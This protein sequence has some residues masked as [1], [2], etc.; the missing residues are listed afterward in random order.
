MLYWA[1]IGD[2][3]AITLGWD[4]GRIHSVIVE[5]VSAVRNISRDPESGEMNGQ[6]D[7]VLPFELHSGQRP[8]IITLEEL[9]EFTGNFH[10]GQYPVCDRGQ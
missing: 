7:I 5:F 2:T 8:M 4:R 9:S 3:Q 10:L 1:G 6:Y